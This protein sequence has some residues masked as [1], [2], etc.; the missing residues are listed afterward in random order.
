VY[1]Q[2]GDTCEIAIDRIGVLRNHV[3]AAGHVGP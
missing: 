3:E 1:L 2:A